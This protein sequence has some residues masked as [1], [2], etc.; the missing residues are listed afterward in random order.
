[1]KNVNFDFN[2]HFEEMQKQSFSLFGIF[3]NQSE[4]NRKL[5]EENEVNKW[6]LLNNFQMKFDFISRWHIQLPTE[7]K[8]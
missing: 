2:H 5:E 6:K 1:M 4:W 3:K 7:S 8:Q